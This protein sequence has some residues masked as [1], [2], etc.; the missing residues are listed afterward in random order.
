MANGP[1]SDVLRS[2]T[3]PPR[4]PR[5]AIQR[6]RVVER[7]QS[8]LSGSLVLIVAG[9]GY[10][11][12]TSALQAVTS[13]SAEWA[14]CS[15]DRRMTSAPALAAHLVAAVEERVPGFGAGHAMR[16]EPA[17]LGAFLVGELEATLSE[18]LVLVLDDVHL[19]V[20]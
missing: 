11:K 1:A 9:A 13:W 18:D 12:S 5:S 10:G 3:R 8:G 17:E 6:A 20:Q 16:G 19:L 7:I 2:R 4:A 15:C 14:W